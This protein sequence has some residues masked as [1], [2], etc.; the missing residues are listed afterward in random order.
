MCAF[1]R[2]AIKSAK[3]QDRVHFLRNGPLK[4][5]ENK[6]FLRGISIGQFMETMETGQAANAL[7]EVFLYLRIE[8]PEY[9]FSDIFVQKA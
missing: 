7:L 5:D 6:R 8:V 2:C 1:K 9:W 4:A 3:Q